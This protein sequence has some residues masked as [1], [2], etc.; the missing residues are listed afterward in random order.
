MR[1]FMATSGS[2]AVPRRFPLWAKIVLWLFVVLLVLALGLPYFLNVDRYRETITSALEKQTGR[3]VTIGKIRAQILPGVGVVVEDLHVGSPPGFPAGDLL[4]A[5]AIR[6]NLAI[7][8]LLHSTIHLNSFELVRPKLTLITDSN[9]KNNYTFTSSTPAQKTS[10]NGGTSAKSDEASSGVR[11]DEVDAILLSDAEVLLESVVRGKL[12]PSADAK[13]ISVTMHN[14][15]I[16]PM[17]VHEWQADSKLSGVTLALGGWSAP[18]AFR[19]GQ[20][21]LAGGKLDAQFVADLAKASDIKG[22]LSVPDVEHAQVN[23]EMSASELDIDK[24]MAAAG[25]GSSGPSTAPAKAADPPPSGPSELVARG[26]INVEKITTKPYAVGPANVEIRVY[27]D[28]AELWPISIGMYGGTLQISSR[29]DRVTEPPRFTANIQM[30]NLDVAKVLDVSPSARG[31]MGGLGEL[32]LQLLGGLSDAWKKTLSGTGKFAVRN[33]HLPGVNLPA[34]AQSVGK[35]GGVGGDTPFTV[36]EGDI[37]IANQR[38]SSKQIH[39]DSPSGT[40]DLRGSVGLDGSLDY[41]GQVVVNPGAVAGSGVV[42]SI[43]GG[44]LSSRV[45][46]ITVPIALGGTIE[47]PKVQPGKGVPSFAAPASASGTAPSSAPASQ[48]PAPENPV[49]TIK[50]LFK[51]H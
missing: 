24:L 13:G 1:V 22:T 44:L 4:S 34:A 15:V 20:L 45:S 23:F 25:G 36:L 14:F 26:H 40:V 2:D 11:L 51:K 48:P 6:A 35:L 8:P 42:G 43:V 9:G 28:R 49:D 10:P 33:G 37:N 50:N 31:K 21:Q 12:E 32:D 19:S 18:I 29:V 16:S 5:E 41:Q 3:H 7:G 30:R 27:T 47:S 39:L 38:V 17:T 46:K